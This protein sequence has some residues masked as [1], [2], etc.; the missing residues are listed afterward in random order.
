MAERAR[1]NSFKVMQS[2]NLEEVYH[3]ILDRHPISRIE[4]SSHTGLN[5]MT[6]TN[7]VKK[8]LDA[9]IV[10]EIEQG[11]SEMGRPPIL[12][13]L[14]SRLGVLIGVE[15]NI[16]SCKILVAELGGAILEKHVDIESAV[17][18]EKFVENL[19]KFVR[20]CQQRYGN[21]KLGVIGMGIALPGNYNYQ[22][23]VVEYIS[24]MQVWN[25]F[26]LR[27]AFQTAIPDVLVLCQNAG[28]AGAKGEIHF[29]KLDINEQLAYIH[30]AMGLALSIYTEGGIH[31]GD[32]GFQGR[33][34]HMVI[35]LNG[36][37]CIC[38][39][40]GCLEMYASVG[41][42]GKALYPGQTIDYSI[43][44]EMMKRKAA[45]DPVIEQEIQS[46]IR[47]L[48]VGIAN[49]VNC[50]NPKRVCI[51]GYLG[52][53]LKDNEEDLNQQVNQMLLKHFRDNSK[54]F[55]SGLD[56]WGAALGCL[57]TIRERLIKDS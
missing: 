45:H 29:G 13:E 19:S 43:V 48:A 4:I 14:N 36:R 9:E 42:L 28:R 27:Q 26:N 51:G 23:G 52:M 2:N 20:G 16:L 39:N 21:K 49:I 8:L 34:G 50:F 57:T 7:C 46:L 22:T 47:Y 24:N 32:R 53:L 38:G 10:C 3:A 25:G 35:E 12:L 40:Q 5:K 1:D 33:F 41:A 31:V 6:V 44:M 15:I 11:E 18:P 55:C 56:E 54:I 17:H 30:G 37:K